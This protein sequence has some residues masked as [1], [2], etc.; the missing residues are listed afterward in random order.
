[1]YRVAN[2]LL[3]DIV[4]VRKRRSLNAVLESSRNSALNENQI[5]PF[6]VIQAKL[7]CVSSIDVQLFHKIKRNVQFILNFFQS[8]LLYSAKCLLAYNTE[9]QLQA[10]KDLQDR[11]N[12]VILQLMS[13]DRYIYSV[14][15]L[16]LLQVT[17][18][19]KVVGDLAQFMVQ[20]RLTTAEAVLERAEELSFP[21]S[22]VQYMQGYIGEP[23][24]GFPEPFRSKVRLNTCVIIH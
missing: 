3:G 12:P 10:Y 5:F 17:P 20:N 23:P 18:S 14:I 13:Q 2:V 19:S 7:K 8:Y 9:T 24:G 1:M 16:L 21:Q 4:K 22:V 15:L 6:I 11:P